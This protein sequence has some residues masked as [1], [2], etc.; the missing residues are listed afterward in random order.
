MKN[1]KEIL[2]E[3]GYFEDRLVDITEIVNMYIENGYSFTDKQIEF[4]SNYAYL[5]IDYNH[6]RWDE[7]M[8]IKINPLEAQKVL[9]MDVVLEYNE[10]LNDELLIIGDIKKENMTIFLSKNGVFYGAFDDCI[11][12]WGN[13]FEKVLENLISGTK[14]EF[15]IVE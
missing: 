5:E 2:C 6:P 10:F 12:K 7:D 8:I 13:S 9:S 14:G 15:L 1:T 3:A 4:V 11:I